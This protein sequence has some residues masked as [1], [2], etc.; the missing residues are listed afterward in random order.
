[1][2]SLGDIK[3]VLVF[4]VPNVSFNA[5]V[6]ISYVQCLSHKLKKYLLVA[7]I[8]SVAVDGKIYS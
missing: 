5:H 4:L 1:M 3:S 2:V 8:Q 7:S 6:S